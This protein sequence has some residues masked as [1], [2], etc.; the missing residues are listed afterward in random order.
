MDLFT[1]NNGVATMF[2]QSCRASNSNKNM[3]ITN[4]EYVGWVEE[5]IS[6]DYGK[7]KFVV[8]YCTWAQTNMIGAHA[9]MK[10]DE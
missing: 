4:L 9:T 5:I 2:L 10:C 3:R 8:L 7:F 6:V 1:C